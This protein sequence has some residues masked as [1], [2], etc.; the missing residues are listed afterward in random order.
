[1]A[2]AAIASLSCIRWSGAVAPAEIQVLVL[3]QWGALLRLRSKTKGNETC[4]RRVVVTAF[5][6][7]GHTPWI[8]D[9]RSGSLCC[10]FLGPTLNSVAIAP[11][12][13]GS[14]F[15]GVN[16]SRGVVVAAAL[17]GLMLVLNFG[18]LAG[19]HSGWERLWRC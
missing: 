2:R 7:L 5:P 13:H 11:L 6:D 14:W 15:F 8:G 10:A 9:P 1:M 12:G 17:F 16:W 3:S 4:L 19:G 18:S